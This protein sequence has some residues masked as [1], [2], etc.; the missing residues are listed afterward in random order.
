MCAERL[1]NLMHACMAAEV[2]GDENSRLVPS[3][4]LNNIYCIKTVTTDQSLSSYL[5]LDKE[6]FHHLKIK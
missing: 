1:G 5:W 6:S 2:L 4:C 3:Q